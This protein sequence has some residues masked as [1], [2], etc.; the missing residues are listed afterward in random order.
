MSE[1][2]PEAPPVVDLS[3][4]EYLNY[5]AVEPLKV[6]IK[7]LR[8]IR[9]LEL[10]ID[11]LDALARARTV[12]IS[13]MR[14]E[15][16]RI[17]YFLEYYR[18]MGVEHFVFVDNESS[19]SLHDIACDAP[20]VTLYLARGSYKA[21]RYGIAWV[22]HILGRHAVG[23]W[24]LH[25][26]PDEFLVYPECDQLSISDLVSNLERAGQRALPTVMVDMYSDRPVVENICR[27]GQDPLSVCPYFDC[28]GYLESVENPL[29]VKHIRGGPRVRAFFADA[30]TGPMLNKTPLVHWK[31]HYAF[32]RSTMEIWPPNLADSSYRTKKGMGGA[33][34]HF[35]F[36]SE[37]VGKVGEEKTRGQHTDEYAR[38]LRRMN[39]GQNVSFMCPSS[40]RFEGWRSLKACG[41][42]S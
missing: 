34:L 30:L 42:I 7:R 16:F 12:A 23:K 22:N 19:D 37:F 27:P 2:N 40:V 36:L 41:L 21:A 1:A 25:V 39:D 17:P 6:Q 11:R 14:N 15:A 28:D 38:Y 13:T 24:I 8:H 9:D 32:I 29:S 5:L 33:L 4:A 18:R 20:D 3:P 35:K 10:K 26:D 31:G